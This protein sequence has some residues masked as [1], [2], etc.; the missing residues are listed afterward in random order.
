MTKELF[1]GEH[2]SLSTS[3]RPKAP[4]GIV[5]IFHEIY[6]KTAMGMLAPHNIEKEEP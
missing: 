6:S 1:G 3:R 2:K 5:L 4:R